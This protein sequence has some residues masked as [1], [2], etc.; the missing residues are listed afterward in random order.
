MQVTPLNNLQLGLPRIEG[1]DRQVPLWFYILK[2]AE[3]QT[4]STHLGEV[5]GRI[6]GEVLLGIM[7]ATQQT[8]GYFSDQDDSRVWEPDFA[9]ADGTFTLKDLVTFQAASFIPASV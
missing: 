7:E 4:Q 1:L 6:V 5:G 2:E 9:S 8:L 3:I